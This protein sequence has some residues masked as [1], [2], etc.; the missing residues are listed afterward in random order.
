[1]K[2]CQQAPLSFK[3]HGMD[4]A[5][6][7]NLLKSRLG[8]IVGGEHRLDFDILN[9]KMI[10]ELVD[11][12]LSSEM[13][14][15]AVA[16]AGL[17]ASPWRDTSDSADEGV[18]FWQLHGRTILTVASGILA[19]AGLLLHVTLA[20]GIQGALGSE[21][22]GVAHEVPWGVRVLYGLSILSGVWFVL[23]KAGRSALNLRPDM[24]L[25]MTIAVVGAVSIGEWF[26]AATV[27]FLFALSLALESWSVGRARRAI[28]AL[29]ELTPPSAS[30]KQADG[31]EREVHPDLVEIGA[32]FIVKPGEKVPLDGR[33]VGGTS[34]VNQAPITGESVPVVKNVGDIVYA[35][36]I[37]GDGA[38]Q[39]ECTKL[40]Q[41]T[42]LAQIVRMVGAAQSR[43]APSEQWVERFARIYTPAV[44]GLAAAV[45]LVPPFLF[46]GSWDHWLYN[47]LVLLVIA[48]PC[49]L[50]ISTPVTIVA[51]LAAAS[52]GGVLIKGGVFIEALASL[53]AIAF[54]KTGTLTKGEPAVSEV[55]PLSGHDENELLERAASLET[56]S[57][58]PL[59]RAIV[60]FAK[61][62]GVEA[63][64][65]DDFQIVQGKGAKGTFT[66]R[67]YWLGSPRYLQEL[68]RET[69]EIRL[70]LEALSATG[71]TVVI[72]GNE[73]HVCGFIA[74]TDEVRPAA[75]LALQ[76]LREAGIK[77]LVM[78]TGDNEGTAQRIAQ[79]VGID[80]IHA[81]LLP[82]DKVA[83]VENLTDIYVSVAMIGDG[84]N[85]APAMGRATLGIAMGAAGSDAAIETADIALMSDDLSKLP[86]LI[87]H[88][89]A[90]LSI[91][92]QNIGFSLFMKA[93][94][95]VLTL[96]GHATLWAAIGADMGTSLLVI[97]N[98]LRLLR[99]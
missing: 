94:F 60:A 8:P 29:M 26:E 58:H 2:Q 57:D 35:G 82:A 13:I 66:G 16:K 32:I 46:G 98:G 80:A 92:R 51:A 96:T 39:I 24:N 68:G 47:A 93:I 23:P 44:M 77:H 59:A 34:Y 15:H 63:V 84:V 72:I 81:G 28:A 87:R 75:K 97:A 11:G 43:R 4:C 30:V 22:L 27:S 5:E 31:S 64:P 52:R 61:S 56:R 79:Q 85:D 69:A 10:V 73:S 3:I 55:V 37:N 67:E 45:L 65:A 19:L 38:L 21:G 86:W 41:N 50:V 90:A 54:D 14:V 9:G 25:L 1:M 48:C 99:A 91:I 71:H 53:K 6:E 74:L 62:R 89:R 18:G 40:S 88:S 12:N 7:V 49:A 17:R 42:T 33:V 95:V 70:R 78:L 76:Q 36:T 83:A 20:G